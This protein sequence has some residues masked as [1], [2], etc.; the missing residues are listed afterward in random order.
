M[1]ILCVGQAGCQIGNNI[2]TL[3]DSGFY[4]LNEKYDRHNFPVIYVDTDSKVIHKLQTCHAIKKLVKDV[5]VICGHQTKFKPSFSK[6]DL[7]VRDILFHVRDEIIKQNYLCGEFL[8]FL[9]HISFLFL[10]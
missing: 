3:I 9:T 5:N 7:F 1:I 2:I 10:L 4:H 8:S 6:D